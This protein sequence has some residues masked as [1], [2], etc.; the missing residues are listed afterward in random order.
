MEPP[1]CSLVRVLLTRGA[2]CFFC[3]ANP[4]AGSA[5]PSWEQDSLSHFSSSITPCRPYLVQGLNLTSSGLCHPL[6]LGG[7]RPAKPR[8]SRTHT[9]TRN[10]TKQNN[11]IITN[12]YK[13]RQRYTSPRDVSLCSIVSSWCSLP[14]PPPPPPQ[15]V[16]SARPMSTR[17]LLICM[18]SA[19]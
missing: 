3:S 6:S 13:T 19:L 7:I 1:A 10:K 5:Q 15:F 14:F 17:L 11:I 2:G 12:Q 16:F 8:L 4:V 9:H 18:A